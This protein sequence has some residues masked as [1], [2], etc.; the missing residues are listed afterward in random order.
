LEDRRNVGE[1]S[2]KSGD[3]M[4]QTGQ[5]LYVYDDDDDTLSLSYWLTPDK[6]KFR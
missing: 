5:I 6:I 3:G 2:G 4:D 1:N